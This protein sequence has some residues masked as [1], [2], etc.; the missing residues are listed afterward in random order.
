MK[1][2]MCAAIALLLAPA[3]AWCADGAA[4]RPK[5]EGGSA[6]D[7]QLTSTAFRHGE[8][9]PVKYTADGAGVSPPLAWINAPANTKA[10]VLIC[11]DPDAPVGT[12]VHWVLYD[13]PP[14][15]TSLAEHLPAT[16]TVLDTA[17]HGLTDYHTVGYG[18]PG[19]PPGKP[20]RYFF[21]L[22]AVD[23]PT[24]LAPRATKAQVLSA[25]KGHV[26]AEAKLYGTYRR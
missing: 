22:Y 4:G 8:A 14:E 21:K 12:W 24:D 20:H 18:P 23:Q 6:M 5:T 3:A 9:I 7:F 10:F 19:P 26:L 17:R 15:T 16:P 25:I 13:I 11:D 1:G 2:L